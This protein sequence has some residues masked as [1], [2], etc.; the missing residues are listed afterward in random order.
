MDIFLVCLGFWFGLVW[1]V[2]VVLRL[3]WFGFG[4]LLLFGIL[5]QSLAL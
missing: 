4:V 5:R 3:F 1:F 2:V